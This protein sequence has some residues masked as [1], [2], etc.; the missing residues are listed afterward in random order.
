MQ[1]FYSVLRIAVSFSSI[2][3]ATALVTAGSLHA[4]SLELAGRLASALITAKDA[5]DNLSILQRAAQD[6]LAGKPIST[7]GDWSALADR[8]E[9][10]AERVRAAPLPSE[11]QSSNVVSVSDF[12]N[13]STRADAM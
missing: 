12:M 2:I 11:F 5:Y 7:G 13:C 1:K 6:A 4:Q 8:Y 9:Q 10:A 3:C